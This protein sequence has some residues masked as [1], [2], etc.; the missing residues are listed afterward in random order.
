MPIGATKEPALLLPAGGAAREEELLSAF[1][2]MRVQ[3]ACSF[4]AY[5]D[6]LR[7]LS[8]LDIVILSCYECE[9]MRR[10]I[11]ALRLAGNTVQVYQVE[12]GK[13][14]YDDLYE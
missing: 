3:R 1:A 11:N 13:S 12:R 4:D 10:R 14:Q 8:G 6:G 5:L 2:R 7:N 9:Q